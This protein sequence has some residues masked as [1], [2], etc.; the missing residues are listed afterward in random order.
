MAGREDACRGLPLDDHHAVVVRDHHVAGHNVLARADEGHV[1]RA[2]GGLDG[3]LG[4]DGL[5]PDGKTH[6]GEFAGVAHA[7]VDDQAA[8]AV[9]LAGLAEQVAEEAVGVVRRAADDKNITRLAEL[10]GHMDHPVVAGVHEHGDGAAG[11]PGARIDGP[12]VGPEQSGAALGLVHRGNAEFL[13]AGN[14]AGRGAFNVADGDG[15]HGEVESK[16]EQTC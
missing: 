4:V 16:S 11:E 9:G 8:D 7:A 2:E 12:H 13:E 14:I 6:L 5:G 10:D 15:F 3:A 1:H